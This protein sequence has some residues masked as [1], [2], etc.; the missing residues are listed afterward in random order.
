MPQGRVI[1][2]KSKNTKSSLVIIPLGLIFFGALLI[3]SYAAQE[4]K[5]GGD[6]GTIQSQT[7]RYRET[8][9]TEDK[10]TY[11]TIPITMEME[12]GAA[13][14]KEWPGGGKTIHSGIGW[15]QPFGRSEYV[16]GMGY[17]EMKDFPKPSYF[18]EEWMKVYQT[19]LFCIYRLKDGDIYAYDGVVGNLEP[20]DNDD[21]K[22]DYLINVIVGG[23][24]AY[25]GATGML[26]GRTPGRGKS[27]EVGQGLKLP[28]SI[29]KLMNGY[30]K[31]PVK[32]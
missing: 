31:I 20:A 29:L 27:A 2:S 17:P 9:K 25:E 26:V 8:V 6:S 1:L 22:M 13:Q 5:A 16:A 28:V 21:G 24:G 11:K 23:T 30:I 12:A 3:G 14:Y 19:D 18:N 15:L 7:T 32:K 4:P 10:T